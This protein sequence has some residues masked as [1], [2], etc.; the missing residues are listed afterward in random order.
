MEKIRMKNIFW[1]SLGTAA[2]SFL[3][4]F[5]LIIVTRINGIADSGLFS[6]AFALAVIMFTVASYGGRAYQVSD[7][8]NLF[9]SDNYISL[10]LFTSLLVLVITLLFV[11][12]NGYDLQKSILIFLLVGHRIFDA[13]ADVFYGIMQKK[14]CLYVSGKSLF[15]KSI[16]SL[17]SFLVIEL[18]TK[19]LLISSLS[20]PIISLLFVIFYDIPQSRKLENF[21]IKI[22]FAG[23]RKIFISTFLPF[24][25]AV[26]GLI[27]VNL[28]RYFIDIYHPN[29]QGYFGIIVMPLSLILLLFSFISN[30][31]ILHL[32]NKYNNKEFSSLDQ[33]IGRIVVIILI[34]TLLI[35]AF[36]YLFGAPI[37]QLMF[38]IDFKNYIFDIIL[39]LLIGFTISINSLFTNIAIIAR[40]LRVT[41]VVYLLSNILLIILCFLMVDKYQIRG[42]IIAYIVTS[43]IQAAAMGIY[44]KYL[45]RRYNLFKNS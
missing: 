39:V 23:I 3:S 11:I 21:S 42:A 20:L 17:I 36:I 40:K 41:A 45:T 43:V 7:H 1:N 15:Y 27:F 32:S 37:L 26:M 31:A 25:I 9:A 29:L 22:R 14:N 8:K 6:F 33:F 10:R 4:L 16:L 18:L 19:N 13:I 34:A 2:W 12:L 30:P 24:T 28:A 38:N 35:C 5:L 44:Y